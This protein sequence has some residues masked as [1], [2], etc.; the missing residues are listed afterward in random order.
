MRHTITIFRTG[1]VAVGALLGVLVCALGGVSSAVALGR[2]PVSVG[3]DGTYTARISGE[4]KHFDGSWRLQ[5]M[6]GAY[7]ASDDGTPIV[8]GRTLVSHDRLTFHDAN[9][10][11]VGIPGSYRFT[12]TATSLTFI[13]V[14]D[15]CS[16]RSGLLA[17]TF[18]RLGRR[19][20]QPGL[21]E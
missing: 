19:A 10:P 8:F 1:L 20:A 14:H 7:V 16:A 15:T 18:T 3:L 11:C 5:F 21:P 4:A 12:S 2:R 9:G 13:R 6:T 17:H